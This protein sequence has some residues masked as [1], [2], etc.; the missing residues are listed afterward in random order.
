ME[1]KDILKE[2]VRSGFSPCL[3]N[4]CELHEHC[5]RW[6]GRV[7]I[8]KNPLVVETVNLDNPKVGGNKCVMFSADTKVRMA[9]GFINLLDRLPR[10]DGQQLFNWLIAH[11][12]RTYAYEYRNGTRPIPPTLQQLIIDNCRE[13]GWKEDVVFDRY[14]EDYEW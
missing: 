2:K 11:S 6:L 12:C 10:A 1:E 5:K 7:F 14:E 4:H 13:L 8:D 3:N 9:H